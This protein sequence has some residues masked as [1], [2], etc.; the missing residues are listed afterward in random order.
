M[1]CL[2]FSLLRR[3]FSPS[4]TYPDLKGCAFLLRYP[5]RG[6]VMPSSSPFGAALPLFHF[7]L[8]S[9]AVVGSHPPVIALQPL[10]PQFYSLFIAWGSAVAQPNSSSA[11]SRFPLG[12][13]YYCLGIYDMVFGLSSSLLCPRVLPPCAI[14]FFCLLMVH[15]HFS[16]RAVCG[17]LSLPCIAFPWTFSLGIFLGDLM[18]LLFDSYFLRLF[19]LGLRCSD[20]FRIAPLPSS[21][22]SFPFLRSWCSF[23]PSCPRLCA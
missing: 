8:L 3:L 11:G 10:G 18:C 5:P 17:F 14:L 2:P 19:F 12:V 1:G 23:L 21:V 22:S 4:A 7:F 9:L 6:S 16:R 15:M 13:S 20:S